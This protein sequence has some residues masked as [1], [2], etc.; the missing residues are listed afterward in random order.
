MPAIAHHGHDHLLVALVVGEH[1]LEAVRQV[2]E[3]LLAGDFALEDLRLHSALVGLVDAVS[4][5]SVLEPGEPV[6]GRAGRQQHGLGAR[7]AARLQL[8][9]LR[10]RHQV[11]PSKRCGQ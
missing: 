7:N 1:A 10:L 6:P 5:L 11:L 4:P 3:L 8:N 2:E 9:V